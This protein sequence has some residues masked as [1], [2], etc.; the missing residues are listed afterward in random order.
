M[1]EKLVDSVEAQVVAARQAGDANAAAA[2]GAEVLALELR[3]IG[4][5]ERALALVEEALYMAEFELENSRDEIAVLRSRVSLENGDRL[6]TLQAAVERESGKDGQEEDLSI[7]EEIFENIMCDGSCETAETLQEQVEAG[8]C[9]MARLEALV[10]VALA[11]ILGL[12][13]IWLCCLPRVVT[14]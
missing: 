11:A 8:L 3:V 14:Y 6:A 7:G 2:A 4:E 1:Q 5:G 9:E 12:S 13:L 10:Q